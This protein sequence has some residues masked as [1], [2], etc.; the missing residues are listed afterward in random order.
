MLEDFDL[1]A[2]DQFQQDHLYK[3]YLENIKKLGAKHSVD[4]QSVDDTWNLINVMQKGAQREIGYVQWIASQSG[5]GGCFEGMNLEE[6][7]EHGSYTKPAKNWKEG[8]I[9]LKKK[10]KDEADIHIGII[11]MGLEPMI[12]GFLEKHDVG[13]ELVEIVHASN[14]SFDK[15]TGIINGINKIVGAYGKGEYLISAIKGSNNLIDKYMFP[16]EY[17]FSP[18]DVIVLGDGQ[19]DTSIISVGI[20]NGA[21]GIGVYTPQDFSAYTKTISALGQRAHCIAPR[22][23]TP[24]EVLFNLLCD[25]IEEKIEK[26][27]DFDPGLLHK[28]EK[29][30]I[31]HAGTYDFVENHIKGCQECQ[32]YFKQTIVTPNGNVKIK[33]ISFV[34]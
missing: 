25:F 16:W 33:E 1:T 9:A 18:R 22:D 15:K 11:S 6:L 3:T 23:Y 20:K 12:H 7:K 30:N 27:C 19:T 10:Y 31:P 28:Y 13:E 34:N 14:F 21:T 5:P 2:V 29:Q 4:I 17:K 24:G 26:K 32:D 8:H